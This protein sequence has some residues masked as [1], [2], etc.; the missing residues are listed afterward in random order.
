MGNIVELTKE[1]IIE[2]WEDVADAF[3]NKRNHAFDGFCFYLSNTHT[4]LLI[5]RSKKP[6]G[7]RNIDKFFEASGIHP[8]DVGFEEWNLSE[9]SYTLISSNWPIFKEA[10]DP[11]TARAKF[12]IDI[13]KKLKTQQ[14]LTREHIINIWEDVADAFENSKDF[15]GKG[16]CY[17]LRC[18]H[19][20][21]RLDRSLGYKGIETFFEASDI[22]PKDVGFVKWNEWNPHK[23][24]ITA[25][26]PIFPK[27]LEERKIEN[28]RL[29]RAEFARNKIRE[30]K[31]L[32]K[33]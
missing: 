6:Y 24:L 27:F 3:A 12:A 16:F 23:T 2:I 11:Q 28:S 22:H 29:V 32:W 33:I 9:P 15:T 7:Y 18:K 13:T 5:P 20:Y 30:L 4:E 17:Y 25:R 8:K 31:K 19:P 10:E 26:W 14:K 1:K 21:L